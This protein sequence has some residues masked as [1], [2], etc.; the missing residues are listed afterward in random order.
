MMNVLIKSNISLILFFLI[1]SQFSYA[2]KLIFNIDN[3][4]F[5]RAIFNNSFDDEST[6]SYIEIY[7]GNNFINKIPSFDEDGGN[8]LEKV[9]TRYNGSNIMRVITNFPDRGHFRIFYDIGFDLNL[10]LF[11]LNQVSIEFEQ[12]QSDDE[13]HSKY[14]YNNFNISITKLEHISNWFD[15]IRPSVNGWTSNKGLGDCVEFNKEINFENVYQVISKSYF[16]DKPNLDS[17]I[18]MYLI[19]G[20]YVELTQKKDNFYKATYT[21]KKNKVIEKWLHCSAIDAC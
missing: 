10:K 15:T 19:K 17:K 6:R 16:Y 12:W 21:T 1:Y 4:K 9:I 18:N 3:K 13:V 8:R 2:E 20:D 11:T 5:N 14:C 7:N